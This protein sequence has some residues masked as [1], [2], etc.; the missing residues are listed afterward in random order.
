MDKF[1]DSEIMKWIR[2]LL[3]VIV[4][5]IVLTSAIE[6]YFIKENSNTI[7]AL[8]AQNSALQV[9]N[10]QTAIEFNGFF[11]T[12][13]RA[14]IYECDVTVQLAKLNHLYPAPAGICSISV[15]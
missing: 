14:Q 9:A 1:S 8:I 3:P 13:I 6:A 5:L 15:P 12:F 7:D 11:R 10:A 4:L 2:D